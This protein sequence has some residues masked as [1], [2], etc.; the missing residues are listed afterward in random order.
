MLIGTAGFKEM[1]WLP[2]PSLLRG[3][4]A[5]AVIVASAA[6]QA[7]M[8][9]VELTPK[10]GL[11]DQCNTG[12]HR[13]M[14]IDTFRR[15]ASAISPWFEVFFALGSREGFLS[16]EEFLPRLRVEGLACEREMFRATGG[17]N[18]H[19]GSIFS[20]GLLCAAAGRLTGR[21]VG[22][23]WASLCFEVADLCQDLVRQEL[24]PARA[25]QTAGER[26]FQEY[27][28]TGARG[29]AASGFAT[30]RKH[31]LRP[32]LLAREQGLGETEALHEALLHLLAYNMD[33]N[34]VS[35]GGL[36]GLTFVQNHARN[37]LATPAGVAHRREQLAAFDDALIARHLSPGGSADLL[38]LTWFLACFP[39]EDG[40][41]SF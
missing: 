8:K 13:D 29:E 14:D 30:V 40:K 15:S 9:E 17:V 26:L 22:L 11:V 28:L 18:T 41:D 39:V 2:D 36:V 19:K 31:G 5:L 10:P 25:T 21:K 16:A 35:R 34:L 27:G 4:N 32:Y 20:L 3:E 7:L 23:D 6:Y 33:T 24:V 38:A 12:A 1:D 37:L